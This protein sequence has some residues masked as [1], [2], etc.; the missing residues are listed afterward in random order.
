MKGTYNMS[1]KTGMKGIE[2]IVHFEGL[3]DG[4]LKKVGLQ[5]KL[6]PAGVYTAGWGHAI[7]DPRTNKF[8][9]KDTPNG[10][11]RS[12]TLFEDLTLKEANDLLAED[13]IKYENIVKRH[14]TTEVNQDQFD[15][16][17][18]HAFN[19][20]GSDNLFKLVNGHY[21]QEQM[22]DQFTKHYITGN[23]LFLLGLLYRRQT[24]ALLFLTGE[25]KFFN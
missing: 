25:L 23:G 12:C 5:P 21:T 7:V 16:L 4:D 24:E 8:V 17:V 9:T 1:M 14:L 6:C 13:L 19:T 18:S 22:N 11:M 20:G 15:A 10:Y 2:L 3:N